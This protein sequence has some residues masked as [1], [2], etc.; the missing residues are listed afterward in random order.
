MCYSQQT[1]DVPLD[2]SHGTQ[3]M[4]LSVMGTKEGLH[5]ETAEQPGTWQVKALGS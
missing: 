4:E 1:Q 5:Q 2:S 3:V